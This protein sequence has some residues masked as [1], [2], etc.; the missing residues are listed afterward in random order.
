MVV[1]W[2]SPGD[3]DCP[4]MARRYPGDIPAILGHNHRVA[5][6]IIGRCQLII[7]PIMSPV[8]PESP[9]VYDP[10]MARDSVYYIYERGISLSL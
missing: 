3:G 4:A 5:G 8:F 6:N 2:Q 7:V 1:A 9:S 10:L